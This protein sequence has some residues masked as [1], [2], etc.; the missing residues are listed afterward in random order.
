M[1]LFHGKLI[2]DYDNGAMTVKI[3]HWPRRMV[4]AI[5]L[6]QILLAALLVQ[7]VRSN[8]TEGGVRKITRTEFLMTTVVEGLVYTNNPKQ[9]EE[10][11]TAAYDE[12]A[13]LETV[14]DRNEADSDVAKI[15]MAAGESAVGVSDVTLEVIKLALETGRLTSGAF[16]IT[17]APVLDLWGFGTGNVEIPEEDKLQAALQRVDFKQVQLNSEES[18]VFLTEDMMKIDL[19]GIAK[20]FI[21]DRAVEVLR[22]AGVTSGSI[23]AGGDIRVIGEK[24]GGLP[25]RIGIRNPRERRELVAVVE[26]KDGAVV[27]SGDYERFFMHEGERYHHIINPATGMPARGVI[28]VTIVANDAFT[29][30]ALST[31]V[32]V[33]GLEKGMALVESL[34]AVETII[35]TDDEKLHI[36]TGLEGQVELL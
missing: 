11:I 8:R 18:R 25:W 31:A 22:Q 6:A 13:R 12:I 9:G 3:P 15:N 21:V 30:D 28:S 27:T 5:I 29:A 32:F 14:L 26:I 35:I 7:M 10:A 2:S 16:D 4:V 34:P 1:N 19:G 17:V 36:S 23:D 24:P 20:G 33:M